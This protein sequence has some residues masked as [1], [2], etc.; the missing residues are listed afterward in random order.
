MPQQNVYVVF[1][2]TLKLGVPFLDGYKGDP[3]YVIVVDDPAGGEFRIVTNVK[4][5]SSL[6]GPAGY[7][8]LYSWSQYFDH[9]MTADL[10]KL[11][12]GLMQTGFPKLDYVHDPRLV[13]LSAMRPITLDTANAHNDINALVNDMLQLDMSAAPVDYLYPGK[14][15]NDM[16]RGWKPAK[17]VTVYGFGFLFEPGHDGLH[18]THMNQG[19][20]KPQPGS[21]VR[22]HSSENGT[23][24]DGAVMVEVD[25]RFEAL[26]VAFQTQLVP[27]DNRGWPI[28]GTSHPILD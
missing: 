9:P 15:G 20:P 6:T 14:S 12:P 19:N 23:F 10:A 5:D 17:N 18:E 8:V 22:D 27:T 24:Q 3:H 13:D 11:P 25:G 2:G 1:K 4:S 21:R 7:H 26:F 28:P 16:R